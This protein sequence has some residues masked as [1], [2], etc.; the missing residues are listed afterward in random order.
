M[1]PIIA[2]VLMILSLYYL[3]TVVIALPLMAFGV[4]T[5]ATMTKLLSFGPIAIVA[6]FAHLRLVD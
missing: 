2:G 6:F 5:I 1:K 4:I 3:I